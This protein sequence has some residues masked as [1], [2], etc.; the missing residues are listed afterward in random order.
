M[1]APAKKIKPL[2]A[3]NWKMN[4]TG[5]HL[6]ELGR[7]NTSLSKHKFGCDVAVC[8]PATLVHRLSAMKFG[9]KIMTGGQDCTARKRARIR[10][11]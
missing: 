1:T 9:A 4:G 3:G 2:V 10:A 5:S 8:V 7:L 6:R 11:M